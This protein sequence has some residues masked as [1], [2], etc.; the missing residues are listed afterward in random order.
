MCKLKKVPIIILI[1][2]LSLGVFSACKPEYPE[3]SMTTDQVINIV[4]VYGV[5]TFPYGT[6]PYPV[7]QWAAVYQGEDKWRI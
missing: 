7:G 6:A 1:I 5:P 2:L 4:F 3:A